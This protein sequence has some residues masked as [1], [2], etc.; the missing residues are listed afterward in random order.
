LRVEEG[1]ILLLKEKKLSIEEISQ[2][3]GITQNYN[4]SKWFKL[5]NGITPFQYR[6]QNLS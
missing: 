4:F 6:K 3:V 5:V 2:M 1:K